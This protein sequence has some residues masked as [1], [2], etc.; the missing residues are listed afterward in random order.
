MTDKQFAIFLRQLAHRVRTLAD[1]I[2]PLIETGEMETERVW[3]GEGERPIFA[4]DTRRNN[5][6]NWS[7]RDIRPMA[8]SRVLAFADDLLSE[9]ESLEQ[10]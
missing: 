6:A 8:V 4:I 7:D 5:P 1:E 3:I 10:E 9:A 2:E